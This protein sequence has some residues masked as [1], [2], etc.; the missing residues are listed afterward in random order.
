MTLAAAIDRFVDHLQHERR[1]S[2]RTVKAYRSDLVAMNDAFVED[3]FA[4]GP[5]DV[6]PLMVRKYLAT[7]HRDTKPRT[8][9]RKLSSLRAFYRFLMMREDAPKNVGHA[10]AT[11]KLPQPLPRALGVDE[12]FR[13]LDGWVPTSDP[14]ALRDRAMLELLYGGGVRASELVGLNVGGIDID[15]RT[16]QVVGKGNKERLV[17]FGNKAADALH[18]WLCVRPALAKRSPNERALF[19]NFRGGRLSARSLGTRLSERANKVA[20]ERHVTPHMLRHSFA[21]HL[22]DGGADLR[23]IQEMLGHASL[24]TTQRYTS[25]SIDHLR[26]VY[27][28]AHPLSDGVG[29]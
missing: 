11:P 17:P 25:V 23:A 6:T 21:T 9:A 2:P 28:A 16:A 4:G 3:G 8:R 14:L 20:L 1:A 24:G 29:S 26:D 5:N 15:R 10:I 18:A 13:L 27:D 12:M 19:L 7:I 22:L